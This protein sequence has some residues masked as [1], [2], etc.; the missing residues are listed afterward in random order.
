MGDVA[1]KT[2][3][4]AAAAGD[5]GKRGGYRGTGESA[6]FPCQLVILVTQRTRDRVD[7]MINAHGIG[8]SRLVR[9]IIARS[10]DAV[11]AE[12]EAGTLDPDTLA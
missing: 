10:I 8:Q 3:T 5:S 1:A 4:A 9:A 12:L 2:T 6:R 7:E 11:E